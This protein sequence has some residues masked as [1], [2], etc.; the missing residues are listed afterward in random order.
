MSI[1]LERKHPTKAEEELYLYTGYYLYSVTH[2]NQPELQMYIKT[3]DLPHAYGVRPSYAESI[4]LTKPPKLSS[5]IIFDTDKMTIHA[6]NVELDTEVLRLI[7]ARA[8]EIGFSYRNQKNILMH[9]VENIMHGKEPLNFS[10]E[11]IKLMMQ[12]LSQLTTNP[13]DKYPN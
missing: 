6:D 10:E 4:I 8:E 3:D 7:S 5:A 12:M 2:H 1:T 9:K 11:E 13:F